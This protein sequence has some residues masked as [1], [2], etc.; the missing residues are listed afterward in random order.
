MRSKFPLELSSNCSGAPGPKRGWDT[1]IPNTCSRF[2]IKQVIVI[3]K[4]P[5]VSLRLVNP[6]VPGE[7]ET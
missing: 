2:A 5:N 1:P 4:Y 6:A 3:N 7:G